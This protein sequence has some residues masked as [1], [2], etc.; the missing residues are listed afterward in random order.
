MLKTANNKSKKTQLPATESGPKPG[1]FPLGS[2]KSR[3]AA[4]VLVGRAGDSRNFGR[5]LIEVIG[6]PGK[7]QSISVPNVLSGLRL[8]FQPK[9]ASF[10]DLLEQSV[11]AWLGYGGSRG[12]AKSGGSRRSM[13]RRRL[14]YP[15]TTGQII[16]RVWEDV[17]LNHV[18]KF[19]EEFSTLLPYYRVAEHEVTIP[20]NG[21]PSKIKF[22]SA[23][24]ET[25]VKRKA[26]G[27]EF[28]DIF[29]DQAEQFSER[30]LKL[31][32]TTCRWPNTPEH[33]CK[34]GLFFN[35]GGPGAAFLRRV[36]HTHEYHEREKAED[37]AFR[38]AYGWDNVEWCRDALTREGLTEVDFYSWNDKERFDYF[39]TKSQ[40]GRELNA[41][42]QAMRTGHLLGSFDKFAG[43]YYDVF[44]PE[45]HVVHCKALDYWIPRWL[46]IDWGRTHNAVCLWNAQVERVTKTYREMAVAGQSPKAL[47]QEIVDRTPE[48]E[49][50]HVDAIYLSHDAFAERTSPDT[51]ALQMGEVFRQNGMPDPTQADKDV[52]GGAMLLYELLRSCQWQIDPSCEALIECL[53]MVTRDED[54]WEKPIKF[55]GDDAFEAARYSLKMRLGAVQPPREERIAKRLAEL[56]YPGDPL[57][58]VKHSMIVAE[59]SRRMQ[60]SRFARGYKR[61]MPR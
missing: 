23:E 17:R 43:Q 27:P 32:K 52:A 45:R 50:R 11:A 29:V 25:D 48:E 1:D 47:A 8:R 14:Q 24:T 36:F 34:F 59:E 40:Y 51:I 60:P 41:L 46:G 31:L 26:Y 6:S 16:R 15:G 53:P 7:D 20:T 21:A 49:R 13:V 10:D 37:F 35:P 19:F 39:I 12:G 4:R 22:D 44:N 56:T 3:A 5:A 58:A 54:E 61:W 55:E 57:V 33:R 9:Q 38:Q 2:L 18:E 28:M 42:P 30:E